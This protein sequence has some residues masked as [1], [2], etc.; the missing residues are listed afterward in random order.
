MQVYNLGVDE[1]THKPSADVEYEIVNMQTN[2]PVVKTAETTT[3]IGSSGEQV[4]LQK[5]LSLQSV[6]PGTY[7][8]TIKVTD[9][10]TKQV[11]NP[12]ASFQ[13]E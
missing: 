10:L 11:I 5:S 1:K 4:T 8:I 2:K 7:R 6:P 3:D 12:S 13:V 9:N